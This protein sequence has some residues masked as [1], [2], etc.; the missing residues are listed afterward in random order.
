MAEKSPDVVERVKKSI[1][2]NGLPKGTRMTMV[3]ITSDG[4]RYEVADIRK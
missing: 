2:V 1:T 4:K 3:L